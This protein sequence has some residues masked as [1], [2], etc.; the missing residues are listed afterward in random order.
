MVLGILYE[1]ERILPGQKVPMNS[2]LGL[3]L[4]NGKR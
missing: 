4:G 1:G 2:N 3:I